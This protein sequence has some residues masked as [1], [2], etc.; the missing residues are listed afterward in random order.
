MKSKAI[1]LLRVSKETAV[2]KEAVR[3]FERFE[4]IGVLLFNLEFNPEFIVNSL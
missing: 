4:M 2:L 3:R 1:S